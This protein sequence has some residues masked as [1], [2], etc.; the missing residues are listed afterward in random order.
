MFADGFELHRGPRPRRIKYIGYKFQLEGGSAAVIQIQQR[1]PMCLRESIC[2]QCCE[3][4]SHPILSP[5]AESTETYTTHFSPLRFYTELLVF[6]R[7]SFTSLKMQALI[8]K[9]SYMTQHG[10]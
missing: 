2:F 4:L 1:A 7:V 5:K 9:E 6:L 10:T 8:Q 3:R